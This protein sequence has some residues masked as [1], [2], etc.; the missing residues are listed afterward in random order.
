M[1]MKV[2]N[3]PSL[4]L[5]IVAA[6]WVAAPVLGGVIDADTIRFRG[7][8]CVGLVEHGQNQASCENVNVLFT[9]TV[10]SINKDFSRS[11]THEEEDEGTGG[12]G[13]PP[14]GSGHGGEEPH[15]ELFSR[16]SPIHVFFDVTNGMDVT[17][18]SF[19]EWITNSSGQPWEG[20]LFR[21]RGEGAESDLVEF[22]LGSPGPSS[23]FL[24]DLEAG[25]K[26]LQWSGAPIADQQSFH[27]QFQV[28]V[29]DSP[30]ESGYNFLLQE[31]PLTAAPPISSV[32]EPGAFVLLLTGLAATAWRVGRNWRT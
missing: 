24:P 27:V 32:P 11:E 7:G 19:D 5:A 29:S 22:V 20:F 14:E 12:L 26:K 3:R 21:L 23:D 28:A 1:P 10:I 17:L 8:G 30:G 6:L 13:G 15:D 9:D 4:A 31:F 18:Y 25:S 16:L 2:Q